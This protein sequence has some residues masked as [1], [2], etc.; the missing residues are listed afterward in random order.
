MNTNLTDLKKDI[1][2]MKKANEAARQYLEQFDQKIA[3]LDLSY[4]KM[5]VKDDISTLK[6]AKKILQKRKKR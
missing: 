2:G 4:A 5:L 3:E 6:T 1:S